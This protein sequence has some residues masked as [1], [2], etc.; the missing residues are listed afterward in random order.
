MA[1]KVLGTIL[2]EWGDKWLAGFLSTIQL[3]RADPVLFERLS[4]ML[5]DGSSLRSRR[6]AGQQIADQEAA[7]L[8]A[9]I[10]K[11]EQEEYLSE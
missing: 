11:I 5:L 8:R 1:D 9:L 7:S 3:G 2:D 6:D 10:T 4:S